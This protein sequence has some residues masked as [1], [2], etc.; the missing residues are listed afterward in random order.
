MVPPL[1]ERRRIARAFRPFRQWWPALDRVELD[2]EETA[3]RAAA[4]GLWLPVTRPAGERRWAVN[5]V[6]DAA[7]SAALHQPTVDAFV[8]VLSDVGAFREIHRYTLD[9]GTEQPVLYGRAVTRYAARE[10]T[11]APHPQLVIMLT[12]GVGWAWRTG[13]VHRLLRRWGRAASVVAVH[14]LAPRDWARTGVAVD[15]VTLNSPGSDAP[16]AR[17]RVS[18]PPGSSG[19]PVSPHVPIPVLTLDADRLDRWAR[20][21]ASGCPVQLDAAVLAEQQPQTSWLTGSAGRWH[22][23]RSAAGADAAAMDIEATAAMAVP[24]DDHAPAWAERVRLFRAVASPTAFRLAV[25]LAAVPLNLPIMRLVQAVILP[26]SRPWHLAEVF[27]SGLLRTV[28]PGR[29]V[30]G[31]GDEDAVRITHDFV[32]GARRELLASGLRSDTARALAAVTRRL[33]ARIPALGDVRRAL[34]APADSEPFQAAA[35]SL[36]YLEPP[37]SAFAA[38]GGP[39]LRPARLLDSTINAT[40]DSNPIVIRDSA[41]KQ[42]ASVMP[43]SD[44]TM[45]PAPASESKQAWTEANL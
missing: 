42:A 4:D 2:E 44:A 14:L 30:A 16:N 29:D 3:A 25:C 39:Y 20:F 17:Y 19:P 23:E 31:R 21:C 11:P 36:G 26:R 9:T 40:R 28:G 5:V 34:L 6:V 15:V 1:P 22:H 12:D 24:G 32:T 13:A 7:L 37:M 27:G 41:A 8:S 38:L 10:F 33:A 45:A 18:G 43:V 35:D